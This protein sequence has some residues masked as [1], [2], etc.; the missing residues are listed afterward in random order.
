METGGRRKGFFASLADLSFRHFV[1]GRVISFLYVVSLILVIIYAALVSGQI[2]IL[3]G[4]F[5][6]GW[7]N[8][9]ALGWAL[10][11]VLFLILGLLIL[12][13]GVIYVRVVLEIVIVL[14]RILENTA[15]INELLRGSSGT[16]S[17]TSDR[18][19]A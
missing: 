6:A 3:A 8:S 9:T 19:P 11:T 13:L 1:T 15:E 10:G 5:A 18:N 17:P 16:G 7:L 14:F 2:S 12:L 4:A